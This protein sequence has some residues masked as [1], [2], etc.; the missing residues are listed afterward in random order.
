VTGRPLI[1]VA[2][3]SAVVRA[4]VGSSLVEHGFEVVE[5]E[6]GGRA[7]EMFRSLRPHVVLL[8]MEMP[9]MDGLQVLEAIRADP[10]LGDT[11]VVF[12]TARDGTD[13]MVEALELG[14]HD[15]LR[16]PF[17]PGE[18]LARVRAAHRV[19]ALGDELRLRNAE[20]DLVSRTDGLTGLWNRRHIQEQLVSATS[21]ARRHG[22]PL[23]ALM[24]DIDHFKRVNDTEGHAAG[25]RVIQEVAARIRVCLRSEDLLA[26]WGGEE[27]L[28]VLPLSGPEAAETV[29][30][31]VRRAVAAPPEAIDEPSACVTVSLGC[32]TL[33]PGEEP[34]AMV[35]RAD[36]ALYDAKR[37]G[38]D[39]IVIASTG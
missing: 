16:K 2:D 8:D 34:E 36:A 32:A 33:L 18:L 25:D 9:V 21:L 17:D 3:D 15:Y 7:L 35:A 38:R 30:E 19:K 27:F 11:P 23:S 22:T 24:V 4:V 10:E 5:A 6:D 13:D 26:R 14:A 1:L 31:R 29:G 37:A 12:L 28:V 20:L 39:R